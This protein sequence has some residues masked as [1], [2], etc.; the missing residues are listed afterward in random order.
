[1]APALEIRNLTLSYNGHPAVADISLTI[2]VEERVAIVGPNGAGKSTLFKGL[3]GLV[4]I[5]RGQVLIHGQAAPRALSQ[6][7]YVP[8]RE[9]IDWA[10]P[11]TV[12]DVVLMGRYGR[13]GWFRRPG[14]ADRDVAQHYLARMGIANLAHRPIGDL[15]GGQ[16][17]RVFLARAL[18]QEPRVL[19]LDEP[20][21][22]VDAPTQEATLQVLADL[23]SQH[24]TALVSTHD[25][26]L[27][28][29]R[30]SRLLLL[31]RRVVAYGTPSEVLNATALADAFGAASFF[32]ENGHRYLTL[33][34]KCCPPERTRA[35]D[36]NRRAG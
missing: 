5:T 32:F 20:F 24:V 36:A 33:T 7:A 4:P 2:P 11:V 22:G 28:A 14:R 25:L 35:A 8:Q 6:V 29:G 17:Q 12:L 26:E 23:E 10:F 9:E 3:V 34:N 27:A 15:S 21:A 1:L 19:L 30:F 13:L 31:N 18:A 16:Q